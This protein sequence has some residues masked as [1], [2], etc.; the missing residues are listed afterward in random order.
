MGTWGNEGTTGSNTGKTAAVYKKRVGFRTSQ[1]LAPLSALCATSCSSY[2]L[3]LPSLPPLA[4]P[5]STPS[6]GGAE[7]ER[8]QAVPGH[9]QPLGLHQRCH[10]LPVVGE[11]VGAFMAGV[12]GGGAPCSISRPTRDTTALSPLLASS[13]TPKLPLHSHSR[14]LC[15]LF[16]AFP[17][18]TPCHR[19]T[20]LPRSPVAP[21]SPW[22]GCAILTSSWSAAASPPSSPAGRRCSVWTFTPVSVGP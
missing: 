6:A 12:C 2:H 11:K 3:S 15:C 5:P 9:Q 8:A 20:P 16:I 18:P 1:G 10:E 21:T 4:G 22:S 14:Q 19:S 13:P 7:G 17:L